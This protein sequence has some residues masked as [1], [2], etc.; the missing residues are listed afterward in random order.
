VQIAFLGLGQ[1]G[2]SIARALVA[3]GHPVRAWTPTGS[4]PRIAG[5]DGI[6]LAVTFRDAIAGA[7]L[8]VLAAPPLAC[9]ELIDRLA[10]ERS[11]EVRGGPG[12]LTADAVVTDVASTKAL[13]VAR[14]RERGLRFVGGHPMAGREKSGYGSSDPSLFV[15]RP[16]VLVPPDPGDADAMERVSTIVSACGAHPVLMD[17]DEHDRAV[18]LISHLPL[19]VSAALVETAARSPDWPAARALA[20]GGW[21]GMTRLA[22]GDVRMGSGI[23]ATNAAEVSRQL[24][25]LRETLDRW[26]ADLT[27]GDVDALADGHLAAARAILTDEGR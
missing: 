21:A 3:A 12:G 13:I 26:Q 10:D 20:A 22:R 8:V 25:A 18:A 4:E 27:A 2:G 1:I 7:D 15:D 19:L 11:D 5:S 17:A 24:A 6:H 16:W 9:L 14:A 23:F